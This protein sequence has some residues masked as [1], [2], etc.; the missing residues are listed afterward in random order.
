[1][2]HILL[3]VTPSCRVINSFLKSSLEMGNALCATP[4]FH[5]LAKIISSFPTDSTLAT[6]NSDFEC[7]TIS[8][9]KAMN[10]RPN[11]YYDTRRFMS[12]GE[13]RTR[14]KISICEFLV[15]ADI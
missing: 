6:R 7:H 2:N 15:V 3:L 9:L 14:A 13:R 11:S 10:L 8:N 1:M 4:E 12:K 5:L